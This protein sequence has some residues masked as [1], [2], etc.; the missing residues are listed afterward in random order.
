MF[1]KVVAGTIAA[2]Y[3]I[4][5]ISI[6]GGAPSIEQVAKVYDNVIFYLY[7]VIVAILV[8]IPIY[9]CFNCVWVATGPTTHPQSTYHYKNKIQYGFMTTFN[10]IGSVLLFMASLYLHSSNSKPV[11]LGA[12]F[13]I[14]FTTICVGYGSC[15]ERWRDD[16]QAP[17][18]IRYM[19][20]CDYFTKLYELCF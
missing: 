3:F 11:L 13:V 6:A 10:V 4:V 8:I 19:M 14:L 12:V 5:T 20:V 1:V 7:L 18:L 15:R 9:D 2:I 16:R 17:H